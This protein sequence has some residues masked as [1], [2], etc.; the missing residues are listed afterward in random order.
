MHFCSGHQVLQDATNPNK[1]GRCL[2]SLPC[3]VQWPLVTLFDLW[4]LNKVQ[5][6]GRSYR[7]HLWQSLVVFQ[8][9]TYEKTGY[10]NSLVNIRILP[11]KG[12]WP[13][14]TVPLVIKPGVKMTYCESVT[15]EPSDRLKLCIFSGYSFC[16]STVKTHNHY[17]VNVW[18]QQ[19]NYQLICE[20]KSR[21]N[22]QFNKI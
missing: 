1:I 19:I 7:W 14:S 9:K 20:N 10:N 6:L 12:Q 5:V 17:V 21:I 8:Y 2:G 4:L 3:I 22:F 11:C 18:I 16:R 15:F 13:L